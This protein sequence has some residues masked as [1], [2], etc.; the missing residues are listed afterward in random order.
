MSTHGATNHLIGS[1]LCCLLC[2]AALPVA[3]VAQTPPPAEQPIVLRIATTPND[4]VTAL[5]YAAQSGLFA[6]AGLDVRL[7]KQ[8]NGGA[9]AAALVGGS[10]QIGKVSVTALFNAHAKGLPLTIV[11]PAAV[12]DGKALFSQLIMAK[13]FPYTDGRSLNDKTIGV[14]SLNGLGRVAFDTWMRK[15]GG[16]PQSVHLVEM[17]FSI[18]ADAVENHRIDAYPGFVEPYLSKA[19]ATGKFR[20][21]PDVAGA[22]AP[23]FMYTAWV[24]NSEWAAAHTAVLKTFTAVLTRAAI[25]TNS[26]PAAT[27]N[28][29][30][31]F[32]NIPAAT[33]QHM[34]RAASGTVLRESDLEPAI[35]AAVKDGIIDKA[36]PAS[37][38]IDTDLVPKQGKK[39]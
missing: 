35:A 11:A 23:S 2:L 12:Y 9:V 8:T 31:A 19:L 5:L 1:A 6:Q 10:Y 37:E 18:A 36:F 29:M 15:Q 20:A 13:D 17:P 32:T 30:A 25:Y 26:H 34:I 3:G 21:I 4:E 38:L 14:D 16:N 24:A 27:V 22:I 7:E 39:P 33:V 28:M